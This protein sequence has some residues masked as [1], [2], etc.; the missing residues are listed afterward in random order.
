MK[1]YPTHIL[2]LAALLMVLSCHGDKEDPLFT[3]ISSELSG[4]TFSNDLVQTPEVNV[5]TFRNFFNGSGVGVGDFNNDD[6]QD[7]YFAGNQVNNKLYLNKGD[8]KFDDITVVAGV[9]CADIWSTGVSVVDINGDGWDDIYVCKSGK[10]GGSKRHNELFINDG[11][12]DKSGHVT[13]SERS[14]EYCYLLN[15]SLKSISSLEVKSD[16]RKVRDPAGGNKLYRNENGK[17]VDVSDEAGVYGSAI[18]FGLG[19]TVTDVNR[20][21]WPDLYVS[22]DFYERDYLY[23]NQQNGKFSERLTEYMPEISR[24]SM[25][26]D[27]ADLNNDGYPDFFVTDMLPASNDRMKSKTQFENWKK[28]KENRDKGYHRQFTRNT[29]QISNGDGTYAEISRKAGVAASDW[30]WG[31]LIFD[32][33]MDGQKDIFVA[34]GLLQDLTDQGYINFQANTTAIREIIKTEENAVLKIIEKMPSVPLPNCAF[35]NKRAIDSD[36]IFEE[37]S[38]SLGLGD[39]GWS[40]GSAYADLDNDGD[41]DLILNNINGEASIYKNNS[42]ERGAH[43]LK[44]KTLQTQDQSVGVIGAKIEVYQNGQMQVGETHPMKGYQSTV[45]RDVIFGFHSGEAIDSIIIYWPNGRITKKYDFPINQTLTFYQDQGVRDNSSTKE[46]KPLW[47]ISEDFPALNR[48]AKQDN[49]NDFDKE[50]LIIQ[51]LHGTTPKGE[52]TDINGDGL[53]DLIITGD[54]DEVSSMLIQTSSGFEH[55]AVELLEEMKGSEH[56]DVAVADYNDD[57]KQDIYF[58]SGGSSFSQQDIALKDGLLLSSPTGFQ[59]SNQSLPTFQ[60]QAGSVAI[61]QDWDNDGDVDLFVG[62]R[63]IPNYYGV[64]PPHYIL[65]NDGDG[66][67]SLLKASKDEPIE[68]WLNDYDQNGKTDPLITAYTQGQRHPIH[69]RQDLI[70]QLP[71]LQKVYPSYKSYTEIDIKT[72][73]DPVVMDKSLRKHV[74]ETRSLVLMQQEDGSY[75]KTV[76]ADKVQRTSVHAILP[77]DIDDDG[78]IDLFIGGNT[79]RVK[80]ELGGYNSGYGLLLKNYGD[81]NLLPINPRIS[82]ISIR[83]EIREWLPFEQDGN[84]YIGVLRNNQSSI[85]IEKN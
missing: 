15:N 3:T 61:T 10:P 22:N 18:G 4:V 46:V 60:Y 37:S 80:P 71:H 44:I 84:E 7:L 26:A 78:L 62:S 1:S 64:D 55:V 9:A 50:R 42:V 79:E 5:Y 31:A 19:V 63:H 45:D 40:N 24:G 21:E 16:Q 68:L 20:D 76:L 82:G 52:V 8:F 38:A 85:V 65:D 70:K 67:N 57:G 6:L 29:L 72:M 49:I 27:A 51:M 83:G 59:L 12:I 75:K 32:M 81:G 39:P 53:L 66:S 28:Y 73:F 48:S 23:I 74:N 11:V 14:E 2:F 35:L 47:K 36:P 69:L 33:D 25:G 43:F 30:S 34:N 56:V 17:F 77:Y 13:F 58:V 54:R 41:Y